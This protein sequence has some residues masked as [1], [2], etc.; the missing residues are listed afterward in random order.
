MRRL[1]I[2]LS[3]KSFV[4]IYKCFLRP[5]SDYGDILYG[6]PKNELYEK[7]TIKN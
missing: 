2:T 1:A 7:R 3:R 6:K 5:N 4:T